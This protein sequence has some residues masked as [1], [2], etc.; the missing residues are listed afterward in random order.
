MKRVKLIAVLA[1]LVTA[2]LLFLYLN[3]FSGGS[4]EVSEVSVVIAAVNIPEDTRITQEMLTTKEIPASV[5]IADAATSSSSVVGKMAI[6]KIY[7]G[8]QILNQKLISAGEETNNTL[9]YSIQPGMRAIS[10]GVSETTGLAGMIKPQDHVDIIADF[11]EP[12]E[13]MPGVYTTM[14]VENVT[15]LAVDSTMLKSGKT[16]AKGA[17]YTTITLQVTPQDAMKLSTT[18]YMGHLR[19]ILRSPL[20]TKKTMLPTIKPGHFVGK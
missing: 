3:S 6:E 13:G 14:V 4:S 12:A 16:D 5:K 1:A 19:A 7:A 18:E 20:D 8:E 17:Y 11:E 10:L 15:V 9:A 2:L